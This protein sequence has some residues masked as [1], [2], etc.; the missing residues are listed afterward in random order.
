MSSNLKRAGSANATSPPTKKVSFSSFPS[1]P[2]DINTPKQ[3]MYMEI[4]GHLYF[5]LL[6]ES[7]RA[8]CSEKNRPFSIRHLDEFVESACE[9][10]GSLV[11]SELK[12]FFRQ[13]K[14]VSD[15]VSGIKGTR[16]IGSQKRLVFGITS[17]L[18]VGEKDELQKFC[19]NIFKICGS[20]SQRIKNVAD[21]VFVLARMYEG[22]VVA[23]MSNPASQSGTMLEF[24]KMLDNIIS[25][26]VISHTWIHCGCGAGIILCYV[27]VHNY[28]TKGKFKLFFGFDMVP[29]QV[30]K[31][32]N[33][34]EFTKNVLYPSNH[35]P[36]QFKVTHATFPEDLRRINSEMYNSRKDFG[37]RMYFVN[38]VSWAKDNDDTF[39]KTFL[40][41]M[42]NLNTCE[43]NIHVLIFN[44]AMLQYESQDRRFPL[45]FVFE[46]KEVATF[47]SFHKDSSQEFKPQSSVYLFC[48]RKFEQESIT[49]FILK[50]LRSK[51][52]WNI[53]AKFVEL[54][55][56]NLS[57]CFQ[58]AAEN[59]SGDV[60]LALQMKRV[61]HL[62]FNRFLQSKEFSSS[63]EIFF[64]ALNDLPPSIFSA[65]FTF[66]IEQLQS[67]GIQ[68]SADSHF[69]ETQWKL[70]LD[71]SNTHAPLCHNFT[72]P[73][74]PKPHFSLTGSSGL[75]MPET[76]DDA[77]VANYC[78]QIMQ[79]KSLSGSQIRQNPLLQDIAIWFHKDQI[80]QMPIDLHLPS[81]ACF[82]QSLYVAG[83]R[84]FQ[85]F[86]QT[87]YDK[88]A[89]TKSLLESLETLAK[90]VKN[91]S[92][93]SI[94]SE[95]REL[96]QKHAP[97]PA[98]VPAPA[99]V[100][101]PASVPDPA[102]ASAPSLA[103][104][105]APAPAFVPAFVPAP[106]PASASAPASVPASAPA[107]AS[108]SAPAPV[109]AP[110]PAPSSAPSLAP[111]LASASAPA[112]APAPVPSPYVA[113]EHFYVSD[114]TDTEVLFRLWE[115]PMAYQGVPSS[116][117]SLERYISKIKEVI[118]D[119]FSKS[120]LMQCPP[121][122][123]FN[124]IGFANFVFATITT[125]EEKTEL[126]VCKDMYR[127]M[128]IANAGN[129]EVHNFK[130]TKTSANG[131][132]K[133]WS[134]KYQAKSGNSNKENDM[135]TF[136]F[137]SGTFKIECSALCSE[138]YLKHPPDGDNILK[139]FKDTIF[140]DMYPTLG[141][142]NDVSVLSGMYW[143][144]FEHQKNYIKMRD[145][146]K[147]HFTADVR[148]SVT[149]LTAAGNLGSQLL[150]F[151]QSFK[152]V[153][154]NEV[155]T[156][157]WY[158]LFVAILKL[159]RLFIANKQTVFEHF[160][161]GIFAFGEVINPEFFKTNK[162]PFL[163]VNAVQ[164]CVPESTAHQGDS[165]QLL[166]AL[167]FENVH[168]SDLA[169]NVLEDDKLH[170][171][172][173]KCTEFNGSFLFRE[174]K[175]DALAIFDVDINL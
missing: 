152:S 86:S 7:L 95:H 38:N 79:A 43:H 128:N 161:N 169:H 55:I 4:L 44:P 124:V 24:L 145:W 116:D 129:I 78:K 111:A 56:G 146:V 60:T 5:V 50:D 70:L 28:V 81:M 140:Q 35:P 150:I 143:S 133:E 90:E 92:L 26:G 139:R 155:C 118:S 37:S 162:N 58:K 68:T 120:F 98:S 117:K 163:N 142:T 172:W 109:P 132:I 175:R 164:S 135:K 54:L 49:K 3:D 105:L 134:E 21:A 62:A 12:T 167:F 30:Q 147:S 137:T 64:I 157:R 85:F 125:L 66:S 113:T 31:A 15:S 119:C 10:F 127:V 71:I 82:W 40:E 97:V 154:R 75:L 36:V 83:P 69:E 173:N 77:F 14:S 159:A 1:P 136:V 138:E 165:K 107:P 76:I 166:E 39:K 48:N 168:C 170:I 46:F 103:P 34:L 80:E 57:A 115:Q 74:G 25:G 22:V 23:D 89:E 9:L 52:E 110:V 174:E 19:I 141:T 151:F 29:T 121:R 102:P 53:H 123:R 16:I 45:Q 63:N 13:L 112:P 88:K 101:V 42:L 94:F 100:P 8:F 59:L 73:K 17:P 72:H 18:P 108:V 32:K 84:I 65:I 93:K 87:F 51:N 104:A 67:D 160:R 122:F 61:V 20:R 96:F 156:P 153:Y 106:A 130:V 41:N 6:H 144:F 149:A 47:V 158:T 33:L 148:D 171:P 91:A 11:T 99:P 126:H 27:M 2:T 131:S 114:P